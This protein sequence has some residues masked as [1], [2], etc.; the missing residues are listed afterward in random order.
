ML[1]TTVDF[2]EF[3]ILVSPK[4]EHP[5]QDIKQF[6]SGMLKQLSDRYQLHDVQAAIGGIYD[7]I[8]HIQPSYKEALAVLKT[9]ERFPVETEQ[10]NSF[11]ELGIYQYLDVLA[12]NERDRL[13]P[14]TLYQS[15]RITISGIIP[16]S[17]RPLNDLLIV[18]ATPISPQSS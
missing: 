2:N 17:S 14:V 10:L 11:S 3:I 15:L 13:I 8:T 16:T 18:T 9:K 4:T 12:E 1:L 6:T 7:H 5:L